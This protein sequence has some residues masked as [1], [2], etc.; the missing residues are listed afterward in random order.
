MKAVFLREQGRQHQLHGVGYPYWFQG[1]PAAREAGGVT[2]GEG[3]IKA[4]R[5]GGFRRR[6]NPRQ[7]S[8]CWKDAGL[9]V[10]ISGHSGRDRRVDVCVT[11]GT[12]WGEPWF[13]GAAKTTGDMAGYVECVS[14]FFFCHILSISRAAFLLVGLGCLEQL[15][16]EHHVQYQSMNKR[17][18][19]AKQHQTFEGRVKKTLQDVPSFSQPR[20]ET[21]K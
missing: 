9:G 21:R 8:T 7:K 1:V 20:R 13:N 18:P 12:V 10:D 15:C 11:V 6:R 14:V 2:E 4:W 16:V 5:M 3:L 17:E 19:T